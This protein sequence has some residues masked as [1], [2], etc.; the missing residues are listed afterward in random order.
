MQLSKS[1][2]TQFQAN[3]DRLCWYILLHDDGSDNIHNVQRK[4][5]I[6]RCCRK[7]PCRFG[8]RLFMGSFVQH[9]KV[10][11]CYLIVKNWWLFK[12]YYLLLLSITYYYYF[13]SYLYSFRTGSMICMSWYSSTKMEKQDKPVKNH[14][15]DHARI[16]LMTM[17]Y[18][19][20]IYWK[21]QYWN[22]TKLSQTLLQRKIYNYISLN[23]QNQL[24]CA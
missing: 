9:E 24:I 11:V 7:R 14:S 5:D 1:K 10:S 20:S 12:S 13:I 15:T 2:L 3:T 16:S 8:S 23:V 18:F 4:G 19:A 21:T 22:Y 6:C 17:A